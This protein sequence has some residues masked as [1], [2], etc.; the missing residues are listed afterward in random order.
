MRKILSL[1]LFAAMALASQ[2]WGATDMC[3]W[4]AAGACWPL[5]DADAVTNCKTNGWL[6]DGGT[7]GEDTFCAGGTFTGQGKTNT[8][9]TSAVPAIGCCHWDSQPAGHCF[10]IY[11]AADATNCGSGANTYWA[12]SACPAKNGDWYDCPTGAPTYAP[13][14][15]SAGSPSSASTGGSTQSS[16]STGNTPII[17]HNSAPVVGLNVVSFARS[18]KIAS[19]KD[20]TVSLFDMNGRQV[21]GQ[22]VFSGTTTISL[23]AQK[24]GVY[25]AVVKSESH[26]QT[27]KVVL[28]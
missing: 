8:P 11:E 12:G 6:F 19:G 25:Y 23:E 15:A 28:K 20:A 22:K 14:S 5:A 10:N 27:V 7:Q 9:P 1:P 2:A 26:K 24:Q 18:L 3:L 13:S 16:S 21:F 17:S 4:D